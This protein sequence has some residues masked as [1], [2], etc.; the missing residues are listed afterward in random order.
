MILGAIFEGSARYCNLKLLGNVKSCNEC[1]TKKLHNYHRIEYLPLHKL[2][3]FL[4]KSGELRLSTAS[5]RSRTMLDYNTVLVL[6]Q[7][8]ALITDIV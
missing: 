6:K 3:A 1:E 4:S 2:W 5:Y 7:H 8:E